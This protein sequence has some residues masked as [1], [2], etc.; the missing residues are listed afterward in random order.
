MENELKNTGLKIEIIFNND[1]SEN[2]EIYLAVVQKILS[3]A[4]DDE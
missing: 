4:Q 2:T 3:N 1:E